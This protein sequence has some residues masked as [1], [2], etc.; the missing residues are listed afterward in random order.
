MGFEINPFLKFVASS[1][2]VQCKI[3]T[4]DKHYKEVLS[5]ILKGSPSKLETFSTFSE[6]DGSEKWLFNLD[7]LRA[8]E[9][10]FNKIVSKTLPNLNENVDLGW[11]ENNL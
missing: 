4:F 5:G 9:G 8:F 2:L 6:T 7:V 10:G 1:K 3:N 11:V